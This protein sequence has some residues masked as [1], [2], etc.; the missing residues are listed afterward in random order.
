MVRKL[1]TG[2]LAAL[3]PA[4]A[5]AVYNTNGGFLITG[6]LTY[7]DTDSIYIMVSTPPAH[8]GCSNAF[9]VIPSTTPVD[10]RK[11]LIARLL[12]AKATNESVN[13]GYDGTG[14]CADGYIHVH[15]IG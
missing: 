11:I 2:A 9:F 15:R 1:L 13:I 10:R 6:V 3:V 5:F 4:A 14:D 12:L 8:S 7:T